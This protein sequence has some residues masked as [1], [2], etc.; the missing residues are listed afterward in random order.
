VHAKLQGLRQLCDGQSLDLGLELDLDADSVHAQPDGL[1]SSVS[2]TSA[3]LQER[4]GQD[5][6]L[7]QVRIGILSAC[8]VAH[9][10]C[11]FDSPGARLP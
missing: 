3:K 10:L 2:E 8:R 5:V 7:G 6:C 4:L 1:D 11:A 9:M